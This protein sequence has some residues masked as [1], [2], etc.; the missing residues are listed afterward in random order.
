M[1]VDY[2][3]RLAESVRRHVETTGN[4]CV[5]PGDCFSRYSALCR[6]DYVSNGIRLCFNNLSSC[7]DLRDVFDE[8]NKDVALAYSAFHRGDFGAFYER[9]EVPIVGYEY[10]EY[11][12][13]VGTVW[14]HRNNFA[15]CTIYFPFEN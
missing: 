9:D 15:A 13:C 11:E 3:L 4:F 8:F 6:F 5:Y 14:I 12:T 10:G 1:S 2:C 7:T